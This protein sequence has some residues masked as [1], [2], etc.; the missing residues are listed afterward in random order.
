M[1]N[2]VIAAIATPAGAGGIGIVRVAGPGA[3]AVADS[4]FRARS[5]EKLG[6]LAGYTARLGDVYDAD[7]R[8]IDEAIALVFHAPRSYTGEDTAELM[9]HGG[10]LVCAELLRAVCAAGARPADR[11]EFTRRAFLSGRMSL[12]EAE[13]VCDLNGAVSRQGER[14]AASLAHGAL[15][16]RMEELKQEIIDIQAHISAW[17][18]FPEEDVEPPDKTALQNGLTSIDDALAELLSSYDVGASVLRGVPTVIV[19]SPNVG[20]ST[21]LN[22]LAGAQKALVTP[23]AG[24]TRDIVEQR[25]QLG[26]TV[27]LLA[28]TA[29]LRD[30]DDLVERLGVARALERLEEASLVLVVFDSSRALSADDRAL[31]AR[32]RGRNAVAVIN[33]TDLAPE[34]ET[35]EIERSFENIVFISAKEPRSLQI[36]DAAVRRALRT[37]ALDSDAPMLANERQ[38][39]C[40]ARAR[41]AMHDALCALRDTTPDVVFALLSEALDALAELSGE[42]VGEAVLDA[43]FARFCVGK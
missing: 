31:I 36:L 28:D 25:V 35:A 18:D 20:K 33:K 22:L 19:G 26:G 41:G 15:Y 12:P 13:A 32:L 6:Q 3:H 23:V 5:G 30:S 43:V 9:C 10:E 40:A 27:L 34:L 29:G 4:V 42:N 2:D 37:D 38:R 17:I 1:G 24:T 16:R 7:G 14:A 21:L 8:L 39:A 11:G